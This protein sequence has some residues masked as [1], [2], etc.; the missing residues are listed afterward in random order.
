[1]SD[2]T[3]LTL[4]GLKKL[5]V[6]VAREIEKRQKKDK[7]AVLR[8]IEKVAKSA[9]LSLADL[10]G[11]GASAPKRR[12]RQPKA[13]GTE[14]ADAPVKRKARAKFADPDNPSKKWTGR[15]RKPQWVVNHLA[16]GKSLD[17]LKIGKKTA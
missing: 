17:D 12:G 13:V 3:S 11:G 15:G 4:A 9:G 8:E 16:A 5:Q 14:A 2:L 7:D 10:L 1:M 6:A